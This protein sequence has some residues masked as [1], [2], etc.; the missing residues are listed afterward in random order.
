MSSKYNLILSEEK[1][2]YSPQC[3]FRVLVVVI[4][5]TVRPKSERDETEIP[6][7]P[8]PNSRSN[9]ICEYKQTSRQDVS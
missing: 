5:L 1:Q 3:L 8:I 6:T 7:Q 4:H 9:F 2:Y